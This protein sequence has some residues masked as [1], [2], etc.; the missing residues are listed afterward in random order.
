MI[1]ATIGIYVLYAFIVVM[2]I[3]WVMEMLMAFN[4]NFRPTGAVAAT[5]EITYT[6]TDPPLKALRRVIP[7]LRLGRVSLALAILVLIVLAYTL[8][9]VL[10]PYTCPPAPASPTPRR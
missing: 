10:T 2:F 7:P 6:V 1:A 5:M 9:A 4:Q 3:R 8:V